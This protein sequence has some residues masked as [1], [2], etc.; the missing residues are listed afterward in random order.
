VP[1]SPGGSADTL[2]RLIAKHLGDT[3]KQTVVVDNKPG[4]GGLIGSQMA[5]KAPPDGYTLVISGIGSHVIAP[6][7]SPNFDP[8]K[9]FTHIAMLGGPPLALVV[10]ASQPYTDFKGFVAAVAADPKGLSW[11]SPGRART[12]T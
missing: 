10:N 9:D 6:V 3:Y 7:E 11:G 8:M 5:A 1:Y 12:V 4:A 2:G